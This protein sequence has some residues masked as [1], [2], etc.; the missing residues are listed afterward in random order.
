MAGRDHG[1]KSAPM[2]IPGAQNAEHR[3]PGMLE[4]GVFRER[5]P[6]GSLTILGAASMAV[7][8]PGHVRPPSGSSP[9]GDVPPGAQVVE[10]DASEDVW[11]ELER[12][13]HGGENESRSPFGSPTPSSALCDVAL[14]EGSRG[15]GGAAALPGSFKASSIIESGSLKASSLLAKLT[16]EGT[17]REGLAGVLELSLQK[18]DSGE[19]AF[20]LTHAADSRSEPANARAALQVPDA[21]AAAP[22]KRGFIIMDLEN[23]PDRSKAAVEHHAPR[24]HT[25]CFGRAPEK[26]SSKQTTDHGVHVG[27]GNGLPSRPSGADSVPAWAKIDDMPTTPPSAPTESWGAGVGDGSADN[28]SV[29]SIASTADAGDHLASA[30]ACA[31]GLLPPA[32]AGGSAEGEAHGAH[33]VGVVASEPHTPAYDAAHCVGRSKSTLVSSPPVE[34]EERRKSLDCRKRRNFSVVDVETRNDAVGGR[35]GADGSNESL[36][37]HTVTRHCPTASF[38]DGADGSRPAS[39]CLDPVPAGCFGGGMMGEGGDMA[40]LLD[41]VADKDPD[42]ITDEDELRIAVLMLQRRV[43]ELETKQVEQRINKQLSKVKARS[44]QP[45][46]GQGLL[47]GQPATPQTPLKTLQ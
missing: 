39:G 2:G 10:V 8:S 35:D 13:L 38:L 6:L 20:S 44:Q 32:S 12:L 45:S 40:R 16:A 27:T 41:E 34:G 18:T 24:F 42:E 5:S 15:L 47:Q 7:G 1:A 3:V 30:A 11:S 43:K 14:A 4:E 46:H 22:K 21:A 28:A 23:S 37:V 29:V 17:R 26:E 19:A 31:S 36:H 25:E 9:H 33:A